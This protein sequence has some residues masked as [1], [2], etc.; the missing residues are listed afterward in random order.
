MSR[1]ILSK[2]DYKNFMQRL[3]Q[4]NIDGTSMADIEIDSNKK[5]EIYYFSGKPIFYNGIPTLYLINY[6]KVRTHTVTVDNGAVPHLMNGSNLFAPGIVEM[7]PEIKKNDM[8]FIKNREGLYVAIGEANDDAQ[9][10]MSTRKGEA[11]RILHY[12]NDKI[13]KYL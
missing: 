8:V 3:Q 6:L 13:M 11:V 4:F 10:I 2:K 5:N 1:H 7:D 9:N 12:L